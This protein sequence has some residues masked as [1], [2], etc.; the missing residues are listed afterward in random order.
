[1]S[2]YKIND[3][4]TVLYCMLIYTVCIFIEKLDLDKAIPEFSFIYRP[5]YM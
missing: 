5:L 1:M 3:F 2:K 4:T